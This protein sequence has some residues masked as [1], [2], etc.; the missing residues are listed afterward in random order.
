MKNLSNNFCN[1]LIFCIFKYQIYQRNQQKLTPAFATAIDDAIA[2]DNENWL[3]DLF[4]DSLILSDFGF[5]FDFVEKRK[6][7]L[8]SLRFTQT[9]YLQISQSHV[10]LQN[11]GERMQSQ[12]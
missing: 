12:Y 11:S 2:Q 5:T 10:F 6:A 4:I 1:S 7:R 8:S 9:I 3:I